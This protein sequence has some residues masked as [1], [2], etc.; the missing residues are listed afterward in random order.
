[1]K[2][3]RS[4][5][6]TRDADVLARNRTHLCGSGKNCYDNK[7]LARTAAARSAKATGKSLRVYKCVTCRYWHMTSNPDFFGSRSY[8]A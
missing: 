3:R 8:K 7:S 2:R 1:M 5:E 6:Q 4:F